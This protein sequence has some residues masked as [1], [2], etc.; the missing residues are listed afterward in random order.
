MSEIQRKLIVV[1]SSEKTYSGM[2]DIPN[3]NF[4]T[5]DLL[6][7]ASVFWKNPSEK[8]FDNAIMMYQVSLAMDE[9]EAS[10]YKRFDKIQIMIGDIIFFFDDSENV[11]DER[12][13]IRASA[14]LEKAHEKSQ[15]VN[16]ITS[17]FGNCFYDITGTFY[18][19]FRKKSRDKFIPLSGASV[20]EV[21]KSQEG[22]Q[23]RILKLPYTFVGVN[24]QFIE[25]LSFY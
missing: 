2:I 18:G 25:S 6:N 9:T 19:L 5:T 22:W 20:V 14:M 21:H 15:Q 12:E 16:I 24:A 4:R 17:N 11:G 10:I 1:T 13:K 8:C 3:P 7:S 23:K